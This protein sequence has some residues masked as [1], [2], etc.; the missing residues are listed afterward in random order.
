M[1]IVRVVFLLIFVVITQSCG[2]H[3]VG[4]GGLPKGINVVAIPVFEKT[5]NVMVLDQ[6]LTEAVRA[7]IARRGRVKVVSQKEGADAVLLGNITNYSVYALS[8]GSDGRA[9][10]YN[11]S[12]VVRII[13]KDKEGKEIFKM[14]GY[15]F[16]QEYERSSRG[17]SYISEE[18]ISYD[19][20]SRDLA[21][22]IVSA[23]FETNI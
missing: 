18:N 12:V 9:N 5:E 17:Q 16:E 3:L 20:L 13:L 14:E 1:Q 2:Y 23:I 6:R 11:V 10:R 15:R 19:Q 22:A 21:K 8:Y 7:E 4:S